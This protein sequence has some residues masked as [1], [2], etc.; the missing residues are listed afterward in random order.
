MWM[1]TSILLLSYIPSVY[2]LN[3]V[4]LQT[5]KEWPK[6]DE[7]NFYLMHRKALKG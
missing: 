6:I 5:V 2:F 3:H 7:V 1:C 4:C